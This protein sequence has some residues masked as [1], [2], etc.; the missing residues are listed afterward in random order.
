MTS[1]MSSAGV[2]DRL[3]RRFQRWDVDSSGSL[4]RADFEREAKMIAQRM[5]EGT[6]SPRTRQLKQALTGM[7]EAIARDGGGGPGDSI[8]WEQFHRAAAGWMEG[9]EQTLRQQLRPMVEAVVAMADRSGNGTI[10][11]EEFANWISAIGLDRSTAQNSFDRID[12]DR[13]GELSVDEVLQACV[14]FHMGRSDFEL[15]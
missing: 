14:D 3:K 9:S 13:S 1:V 6:D 4:E 10:E 7:F 2:Q 5:G 11:R 12:T 8:S 15:L